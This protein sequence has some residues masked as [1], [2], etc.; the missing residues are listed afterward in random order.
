[1]DKNSGTEKKHAA[2]TS[3]LAAFLLTGLKLLV[4]LSTGSLGIL[5]EAAHS[6]LDLVASAITFFAIRLAAQPPDATHSYGHGK[7]ENL[8]ALV[9][10]LLLLLTC[11]WIAKEAVQNMFYEER[12]VHLTV[13]AFLILLL[14]I[15]VD[16]S[17][18]RLLGKVAKKHKSQALE[19]DALHFS[20][21]MLSSLVVLLGLTG[22]WLADF[23]AQGSL[24]RSILIRADSLAALIVAFIVATV[25]LRLGFRAVNALMD[26]G[27]IKNLKQVEAAVEAI[28][29]VLRISRLRLRESGADTFID[30]EIILP[31]HFDLTAAHAVTSQ[32]EDA[33][34]K[35]LPGADITIHFEPEAHSNDFFSLMRSKA[36][37]HDLDVHNIDVN[38]TG[39]TIYITLHA[40]VDEKLTLAEAHAKA[41]AF[42]RDVYTPNFEVLVHL[43]PRHTAESSATL[44]PHYDQSEIPRLSQIIL[45]HLEEHG[46]ARSFHKIRLLRTG[47]QLKLSFHCNLPGNSNLRECH[48]IVSSIE[49]DLLRSCPELQS[50]SIHAEPLPSN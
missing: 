44:V 21:D 41:Q 9:E 17:R 38:S 5:A 32:V 46:C 40:E 14:S 13:W 33:I 48:Q 2:L 7:I 43:E 31:A 10:T 22:V 28:P 39:E 11:V 49:K 27:S 15:A 24:V 45:Q 4:A 50:V 47:G 42:E 37:L 36:R 1:M 6:A 26:A 20:I 8:S 19:A 12:M 16:F 29:D 34:K 3:L 25:S 30:L 23:Y 18:S 35:L